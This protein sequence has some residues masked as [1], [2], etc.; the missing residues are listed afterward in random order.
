MIK[1]RK[2]RYIVYLVLF[3]C[4]PFTGRA[5][6]PDSTSIIKEDLSN[7]QLP[8]LSELFENSKKSA[9]VEYF[10]IKKE[11]QERELKT[12]KR[13]WLKY[14]RV[15]AN[16]Q[17]GTGVV[18][19]SSSSES[20][21]LYQYSNTKQSW[22]SAGASVSIPVDDLFD[23]PNRVKKQRLEMHATE[24][25]VEK[26]HD[27]QKLRIIEAYTN[28][29]QLLAVLKIKIEALAIAD[30][31]YKDSENDFI[32]GTIDATELNNRKSYQVSAYTDYQET[33]SALKNELLQLE[34]LS[35][36]K[37]LGN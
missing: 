30:A 13:S 28:A 31:Q 34:V 8:P 3:F 2:F 6:K 15:G 12:E 36:T 19:S 25:E 1:K 5:Q 33:K 7:L 17:Y 27:E 18:N 11:V 24:V 10:N 26:W 21:Y 22:Y 29:E 37:I 35:K 23:R 9:A 16:Y 20:S 14:F 4:S 32:N